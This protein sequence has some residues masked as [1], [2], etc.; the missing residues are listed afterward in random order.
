MSCWY[1]ECIITFFCCGCGFSMCLNTSTTLSL[2]FRAAILFIRA[3]TLMRL[4]AN[5]FFTR[6]FSLLRCD[7]LLHFTVAFPL[8]S[9][10]QH[11]LIPSSQEQ[12]VLWMRNVPCRAAAFLSGWL[13]A[14]MS[15]ANATATRAPRVVPCLLLRPKQLLHLPSSEAAVV[16]K[17][18]HYS[19]A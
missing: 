6:A 3:G 5:H 12:S 13:R 9:S 2:I 10:L 15:P 1:R 4:R 19:P 16:T 14:E 18:C 8:L 11:T 7:G 17:D